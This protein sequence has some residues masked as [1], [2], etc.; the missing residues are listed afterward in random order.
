MRGSS[1]RGRGCVAAVILSAALAAC[2][3]TGPSSSPASPT[4]GPTPTEGAVRIVQDVAY[5]V[6]P[7]GQRHLLSVYLP[8]RAGGPWPTVVMF[9]G[10]GAPLLPDA[11]LV[12]EAGAV[13]FA[14]P[15]SVNLGWSSPAAY[16]ADA[17]AGL[18]VLACSVRYARAKAATYGGD[19]SNLTLYGHSGGANHAATLAFADPEAGPGCLVDDGSTVPQRLVLYEGDWLLGG[20][21]VW[22]LL[23][24]QDP[25]ILDTAAPWPFLETAA[26]I[27]VWLLDSH[28]AQLPGRDADPFLADRD[29]S[30]QLRA[31]FEQA[32][33]LADDAISMTEVQRY[34]EHRLLGLGF[35]VTFVEL[36]GSA[37]N[38]ISG[39]A[40]PS[41]L[42]A[43]IGT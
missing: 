28:D 13:V 22:D 43:I 17:A 30:G 12:A 19:P 26:R 11:L 8:T 3:E 27:P 1:M 37:H 10:G 41:V 34:F 7:G 6:E 36:P 15:W 2:G 9:H 24:A 16:R 21:A 35:N 25:T 40:L 5:M 38:Y 39:K 29:P 18:G 32:G 20:A 42:G 4:P 14:P 33:A 31:W 23:L